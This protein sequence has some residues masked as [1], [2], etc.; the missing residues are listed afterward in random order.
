MWHK[1]LL[2]YEP[3][4][5]FSSLVKSEPTWLRPE[6]VKFE[7]QKYFCCINIDREPLG[8]LQMKIS[9]R[10]LLFVGNLRL[11]FESPLTEP[12]RSKTAHDT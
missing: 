1:C 4:Y 5:F 11:P 9:A 10:F 2:R 6:E 7:A 8:S 12:R 3:V